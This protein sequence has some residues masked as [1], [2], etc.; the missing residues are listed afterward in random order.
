MAAISCVLHP[1]H[2]P[3]AVEITWLCL[4]NV[5]DRGSISASLFHIVSVALVVTAR[6]PIYV[7]IRTDSVMAASVR[8][9]AEA[10][11]QCVLLC[12]QETHLGSQNER[13][14]MLVL[15]VSVILHCWCAECHE[16]TATLPLLC[17]ENCLVFSR[18]K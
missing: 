14:C 1:I 18:R 10:S 11:D 4:C 17:C 15:H 2:W 5:S 12:V 13:S 16:H 7:A 6:R 3:Q 8:P 9:S